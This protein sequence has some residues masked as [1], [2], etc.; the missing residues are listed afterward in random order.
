LHIAP[1]ITQSNQLFSIWHNVNILAISV[2][3]SE[4]CVYKQSLS[5]TFAIGESN[6]D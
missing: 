1:A 3:I 6:N 2:V 4:H 5:N